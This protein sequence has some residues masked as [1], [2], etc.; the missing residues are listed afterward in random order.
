MVKAKI[1]RCN[2][3]G[4]LAETASG[5]AEWRLDLYLPWTVP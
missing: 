2:C 1:E 4:D 5:D 3:H